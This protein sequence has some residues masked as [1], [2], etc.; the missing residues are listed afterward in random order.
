MENHINQNLAQK[1]H[2]PKNYICPICLAS[3]GIE[4]DQTLIDQKDII[5]RDDDVMV[6][7][8]S[9]FIENSEGHLIIVPVKHFENLYE[10]PDEVG[11][12]I[13]SISKKFAVEM[14]HIYKCDGINVL[15]NN[16]PA[17][18]QHAFHYHMHLFPRYEGVELWNKMSSKRVATRKE[19]DLFLKRFKDIK[20]T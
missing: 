5:Y 2:A 8:S 10:M 11:A 1:S 3:N 15:Q 12:K 6:F 7:I 9:F 20:L 19:K 16:E 18:N 17:A 13:F 4:N 14:K